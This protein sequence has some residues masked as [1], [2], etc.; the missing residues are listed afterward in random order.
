MKHEIPES[1]WN[2]FRQLRLVALER[3]CKR[4]LDEVPRFS[5]E[6]ERGYHER[7][8]ELLGWLGERNDELAK[9]FDDPRRSQMPL[10]RLSDEIDNLAD[11]VDKK[12]QAQLATVRALVTEK[13]SLD[14]ARVHLGL[15]R[16]WLLVH[17]PVT[18]SLIVMMVLHV[19]VV[20]A[21]SSGA[22]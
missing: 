13:D 20:Y 5:F 18:Y 16:A 7:Y 4:V 17:V 21:Y 3:F 15:T 6:T 9:A 19:L 14:F 1:D 2:I 8:L 12:G 22:G 11:Y 10:Q